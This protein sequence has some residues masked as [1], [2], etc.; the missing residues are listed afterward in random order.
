VA[1]GYSQSKLARRLRVS[2]QAV[3]AWERARDGALPRDDNARVLADFL[4]IP[5]HEMA[6]LV[7]AARDE[8]AARRKR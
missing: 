7:L 3:A 1:G 8:A 5:P 2:R 4:L 6:A